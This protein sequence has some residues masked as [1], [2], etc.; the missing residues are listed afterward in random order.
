MT[1]LKQSK[2]M[3]S[4]HIAMKKFTRKRYSI[5]Y[6]YSAVASSFAELC[7]S[8][9]WKCLSKILVPVN[10]FPK[11]YLKM[12][13]NFIRLSGKRNNH[14]AQY[15]IN[16]L[17]RVTSHNAQLLCNASVAIFFL[18]CTYTIPTTLNIY[19]WNQTLHNSC[20]NMESKFF[21]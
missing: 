5:L 9:N 1:L 13:L 4:N 6:I 18:S 12:R 21:Q 14:S 19:N 7:R 20:W 11:T 10:T 8:L 17:W 3:S 2:W 15:L 16:T